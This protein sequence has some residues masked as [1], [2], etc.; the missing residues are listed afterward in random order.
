M[1]S[2]FRP[3]WAEVYRWQEDL[4]KRIV[5]GTLTAGRMERTENDP[6]SPIVPV[7]NRDLQQSRG[8]Q[9]LLCHVPGLVNRRWVR[10]WHFHSPPWDSAQKQ[11]NSCP[12]FSL[13]FSSSQL[14]SLLHSCVSF[15]TLYHPMALS[16]DPTYLYFHL[17]W[18][19][20]F[21][22]SSPLPGG[23]QKRETKLIFTLL[24]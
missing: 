3:W 2:L 19:H 20:L 13:H 21:L 18:L 7:S 8:S 4:W 16:T 1:Q 6:C 15:L 14:T 11:L 12:Y 9:P 10:C 23:S 24:S 17:C 22:F 5:K